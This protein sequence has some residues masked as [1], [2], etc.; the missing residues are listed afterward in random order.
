MGVQAEFYDTHKKVLSWLRLL[1]R[2][3]IRCKIM[4]ALNEGDKNLSQ[5]RELLGLSSSTILH[6]M[7]D[8]ETE[9]L[10]VST[11]DGYALTNIGEAQAI[12]VIDLIKAIYVLSENPEFWLTHDISGIPEVLLKR[13]GDLGDC[14]VVKATTL[15]ILKPLTDFIQMLG[16]SKK[17]LGISPIFH[18]DFPKIVG[19]LLSEQV[20]VKLIL[21]KEILNKLIEYDVKIVEEISRRKNCGVWLNDD[22]KVAFTVTDKFISL[23]LFSVDG[24]YDFTCDLMGG[25]KEAIVWGDSLFEYYIEKSKRYEL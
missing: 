8:M 25:S 18:P 20:S 15:D 6:A 7:R 23:G 11:E 5:L 2:S 3:E 14:E 10:I 22:L 13:I 17:M 1:A 16:N 12:L 21:T 9:S 24:V 19:K 4:L